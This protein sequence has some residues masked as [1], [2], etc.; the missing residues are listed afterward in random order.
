MTLELICWNNTFLNMNFKSIL[1]HFRPIFKTL[2]LKSQNFHSNEL[3]Q[4][5]SISKLNKW[6]IYNFYFEFWPFLAQK[7]KYIINLRFC[8]LPWTCFKAHAT[9]KMQH[10]KHE[11]R[12]SKSPSFFFAGVSLRSKLLKNIITLSSKNTSLHFCLD[13]RNYIHPL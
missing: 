4:K 5:S 10:S 3:F 2:T 8:G 11:I 9:R 6:S 1:G 12:G 7:F 13:V